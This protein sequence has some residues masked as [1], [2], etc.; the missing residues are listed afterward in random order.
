MS[1]LFG[2]MLI[3]RHLFYFICY[4]I[5]CTHFV[6]TISAIYIQIS[7]YIMVRWATRHFSLAVKRD[8][9]TKRYDIITVKFQFTASKWRQAG[10][11]P[12]GT[13]APTSNERTK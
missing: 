5:Y 1:L 4:P 6:A 2:L 10:E 8:I 11:K 12:N 9:Y 13:H 3:L 7:E